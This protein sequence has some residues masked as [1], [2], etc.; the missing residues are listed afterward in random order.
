MSLLTRVFNVFRKERLQREVD[1]ELADHIRH[2]MADGRSREEAERALGSLLRHRESTVEVKLSAR[3]DGL[4]AD[5]VFGLRQFRRRKAAT[6]AAVLSL[7]LAIGSVTSAFRL[8]D[9]ALFRP[10][11]V[12]DPQTL[13]VAGHIFVDRQ[14]GN[15]DLSHSF[16]YPIFR[17]FREALRDKADLM[18]LS[19]ARKYDITYA[20]DEA[21]EKAYGQHVSG[22]HFEVLGVKPALG[23]LIGPEDDLKPGGHPVAVLS[24]DYWE[25]RFQ[26]DPGVLGRTFRHGVTR[27][28][29]IGVAQRGYTGTEP[30]KVTSYFIPTMQSVE[31]VERGGWNWIRIWVRPKPG[32]SLEQVRQPMQAVLAEE[33]QQMSLS[34]KASVTQREVDDY[35]QAPLALVSAAAGNSYTQKQYRQPLF[36]LAAVA[37]LVLL[38]ACANVANLLTAQAGA[39]AK[40][41]ALRV[42]IGAGRGRL[43]Q[44]ILVECLMLAAAAS[45]LGLLFAWWATPLVVSMINPADDPVRLVMP[46]DWRV[47]AFSTL[48]PLCV[49]LLFGLVPALR[50]SSVKPASALKGGDDPHSR[51]RLMNAMIAIQVAFCFVVHFGAGLFVATLQRVSSQS[52]GFGVDRTL[53]LETWVKDGGGIANLFSSST[54][55]AAAWSGILDRLRETPGVEA[56]GLSNWALMSGNDSSSTLR[57]GKQ[58]PDGSASPF[59][60]GISTGWIDAM[61]IGWLGGARLPARRAR[62]AYGHRRKTGCGRGNRERRVRTFVLWRREPGGQVLRDLHAGPMGA[63]HDCRVRARCAL[64]GLAR[65]D[66]PYMVSA[67]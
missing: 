46:A 34:W 56:A 62:H 8:I 58:Q 25:S 21:I 50:A 18:A 45:A 40:E 60:L 48:L 41:M 32:V 15:S 20:G 43:M 19:S 13:L 9:A 7:A 53:L 35:V 67:V 30:G 23:R 57:V 28:E 37:V 1:E 49:T 12:K 22:A 65:T 6:A 59:L 2:A 47:V 39:R 10:L 61:R 11:P 55:G 16:S 31:A 52:P 38:I 24:D 63:A 64:P 44:L 26:R 3:L 36:V 17:K 54:R 4:R 33:R 66:P 14:T 29:I 51:R 5:T 27:Y 42:S